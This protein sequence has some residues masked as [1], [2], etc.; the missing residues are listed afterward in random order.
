MF[1]STA[2]PTHLVPGSSAVAMPWPE[3]DDSMEDRWAMKKG[4]PGCLVYTSTFKGV[5]M[6]A[7]GCQFTI[8]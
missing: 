6:V 3:E 2:H 7:K 1:S 5:P 8:S 4:G